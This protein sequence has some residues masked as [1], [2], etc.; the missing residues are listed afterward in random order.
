MV[1]V[2]LGKQAGAQQAHTHGLWES[3]EAVP[4]L[5]IAKSKILCGI[6]AVEN[7]FRQP[8]EIEIVE[9]NYD[10]FKDSDQRLLKVAQPHVADL[11][12]SQLDLLIVDELGK[13]ISGTGMDLNVIGNW[14]MNG[15]TREPDFRRIAVL[16]LTHASLG[17]GLGIGLADFTTQR[18]VDE[19]DVDVTY[20]NL[21]TATEPGVMNTKEGL[22]PLALNTDQEAIETALFSSL[23]SPEGPRVCRIKNTALLDKF[24]VSPALMD[25]LKGNRNF[26]IETEPE[27]LEFNARG[28]LF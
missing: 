19:F 23:A 10:A 17:N 20:V 6:A 21:F 15:G 26:S 4:E 14:R 16:S 9:P 8:V 13:D 11:P 5:T 1:T 25:E 22:L 27:P 24:W 18:F 12:F 2:G 3:V 7:G 28:N